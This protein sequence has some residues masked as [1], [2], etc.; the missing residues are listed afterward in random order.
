MGQPRLGT[1]PIRRLFRLFSQVLQPAFRESGLS[2]LALSPL[3]HGLLHL[4]LGISD[5]ISPLF[6]KKFG[7]RV[8]FGGKTVIGSLAFFITTMTIEAFFLT[9]LSAIFVAAAVTVVELVS[10]DDNITVPL[11]TGLLLQII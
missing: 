11:V 5:A 2:G 9:Y 7:T 10:V 8:V 6:G 4:I 1:Q 3:F